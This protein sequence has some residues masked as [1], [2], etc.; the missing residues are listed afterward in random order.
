MSEAKLNSETK[1]YL[2]LN[3]IYYLISVHDGGDAELYGA[4]ERLDGLCRQV[5]KRNK[6]F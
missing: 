1:Q 3:L 6:C 4:M 5:H 2:N